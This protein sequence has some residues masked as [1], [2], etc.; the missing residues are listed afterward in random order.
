MKDLVNEYLQTIRKENT[1]KN[2]KVSL[3][4]FVDFIEKKLQSEGKDA[5]INNIRKSYITLYQNYLIDKGYKKSSIN[6]KM[7]AVVSFYNYLKGDNI[8]SENLAGDYEKMAV[9]QHADIFLDKEE[10]LLLLNYV[11]NMKRKKGDRGFQLRKSRDKFLVALLIN[12]GLRISEALN[13]DVNDI[14]YE[15]KIVAKDTKNGTDFT[16]YLSRNTMGYLEEYLQMR[17][18]YNID[19]NKLFVS[20]HGEPLDSSKSA[21]NRQ[22]KIYCTEA[23]IKKISPHKLRHTSAYLFL[24]NGGSMKD[25]QEHLN[26][27]SAITTAKIYAHST[28]EDRRKYSDFT[29][30]LYNKD[31]DNSREL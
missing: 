20:V 18:K 14:T 25:L 23:G 21:V 31:G 30:M 12:T 10:T 9:D 11:K 4:Q 24:A 22:L 26:H 8:V 7:F 17:E 5:T 2:Y 28:E 29:E 16:T 3:N 13:L 27:K 15:G 19:C 6:G 1:R